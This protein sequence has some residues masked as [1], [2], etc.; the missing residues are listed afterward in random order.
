MTKAKVNVS[1]LARAA[2]LK[3]ALVHNRLY[4]GMSL[5]DAL[6][7]QKYARRPVHRE[8]P[9]PILPVHRVDPA[10]SAT[11]STFDGRNVSVFRE[12]PKPITLPPLTQKSPF[13]W[14]Y[15]WAGATAC[16]A[17]ALLGFFIN[18]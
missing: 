10:P 7:S 6:S 1:A 3:P 2:G 9:K 13:R 15:F 17:A 4:A 14:S 5:E 16:T 8:D 11:N 12:A 18:A